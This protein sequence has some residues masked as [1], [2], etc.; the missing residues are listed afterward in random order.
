MTDNRKMTSIFER[1]LTVWVGRRLPVPWLALLSSI[2]V[3][4]AL[5]LLS[6]FFSRKWII[7]AKGEAWF[8]KKFLH[9]LTP[10]TIIALLLTLVLLFSFKGKVILPIH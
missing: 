5:P 3:Y 10:I 6:G 2:G 9:I 1:Y 8:K 7:R 4:V